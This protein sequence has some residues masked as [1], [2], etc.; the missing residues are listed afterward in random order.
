MLLL[1]LQFRAV[2]RVQLGVEGQDLEA[3]GIGHVLVQREVARALPRV[4]PPGLAA[5]GVDLAEQVAEGR[6]QREAHRVGGLF[7]HLAEGVVAQ[8]GHQRELVQVERTEVAIG[9]QQRAQGAQGAHLQHMVPVGR[10]RH[11]LQLGLLRA[12]AQLADQP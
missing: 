8:G 7:R 11:P 9:G 4:D 6:L 1:V 10:Q 3:L 12:E 5:T 2:L